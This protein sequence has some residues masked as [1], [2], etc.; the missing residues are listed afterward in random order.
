MIIERSD[1]GAYSRGGLIKFLTSEGGL[2]R[3]G[4]YWKEGAYSRIY[5]IYRVAQKKRNLRKTTIKQGIIIVLLSYCCHI[6]PRSF[7][8]TL[9]KI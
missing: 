3:G 9:K 5:G 1:G 7:A 8:T 4:A 6:H 2:I